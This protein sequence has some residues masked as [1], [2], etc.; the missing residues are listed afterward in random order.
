MGRRAVADRLTHDPSR[1]G[2]D[3][4]SCD[5]PWPCDPAREEL[6]DQFGRDRVGLS[7][8]MA[9]QLDLAVRE[10]TAGPQEL[11]E[12]FVAWTR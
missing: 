4:E 9:S 2:W 3:C 12:R 6:A 7:I 5:A 8:Y 10:T 11:H 1:P